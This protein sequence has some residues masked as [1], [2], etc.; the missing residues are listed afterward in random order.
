M[1]EFEAPDPDPPW[2][3]GAEQVG[4]G[5][6]RAAPAKWAGGSERQAAGLSSGR[7]RLSGNNRIWLVEGSVA[8]VACEVAGAYHARFSVFPFY[9]LLMSQKVES[10]LATLKCVQ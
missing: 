1:G 9:T 5:T 7:W 10:R 3:L 8:R 4:E 2:A 6:P